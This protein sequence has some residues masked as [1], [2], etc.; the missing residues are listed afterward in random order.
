VSLA[1]HHCG[2]PTIAAINGSAVGIGMT[3]VL[4]C[5]IHVVSVNAKCGFVFAGRGIVM[6]ACSSFFFPRLI[7]A[8]RA[9]HLCTTGAVYPASHP[10]LNTLFSEVL[11]TPE[12]TVTRAL[13]LADEVAQST[14]VVSTKIMRD[15]IYREP[16]VQRAHIW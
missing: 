9:I 2:K 10:L 4:P 15:L 6:E 16:R 8:S 12:A 14:S 11:L 1:I 13:E 7:G 5:A 3:M